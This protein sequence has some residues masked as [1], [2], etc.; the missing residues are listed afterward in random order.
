VIGAT[1]NKTGSFRF[2]ATKVGKDTM[3]AQI[4][5]LVEEAQG[6]KAPI[7]RMV[8]LISSYFVPAVIVVAVVTFVLWYLFGPR[9]RSH[10]PC[11]TSSRCSSSPAP[12]P[13]AWPPPPPSWW[14]PARAPRT[15]S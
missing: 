3:L 2:K 4:V 14:A 7:Q 10:T 6:S 8:D 1:L 15:A 12:A 13:W 9:P 11:S 5:R